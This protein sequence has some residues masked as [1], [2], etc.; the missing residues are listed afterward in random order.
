MRAGDD[1]VAVRRAAASEPEMAR[2]GDSIE[3][4]YRHPIIARLK[5]ASPG[6]FKSLVI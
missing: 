4:L 2:A 5:S 3:R 1:L 6:G